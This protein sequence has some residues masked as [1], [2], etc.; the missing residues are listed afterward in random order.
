MQWRCCTAKSLVRILP[1]PFCRAALRYRPDGV[2]VQKYIPHCSK[3]SDLDYCLDPVSFSRAF[4][5]WPGQAA[6]AKQPKRVKMGQKRPTSDTDEKNAKA[7]KPG[8]LVNPLRWRVLKDG[9]VGSGTVLYWCDNFCGACSE[10]EFLF[11]IFTTAYVPTS[12][13]IHF[14]AKGFQ[15]KMFE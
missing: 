2:H 5:S 8:S 14:S 11:S 9:E 10:P 6:S 12:P 15:H 7:A 3:R 1:H 4:V 13:M